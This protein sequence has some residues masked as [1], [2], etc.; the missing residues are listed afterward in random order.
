VFSGFDQASTLA[1]AQDC[2]K[3]LADEAVGL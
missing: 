1:V 3:L 2:Q